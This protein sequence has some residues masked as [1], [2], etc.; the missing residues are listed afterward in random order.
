MAQWGCDAV[1]QRLG[2]L[3]S[4]L[5]GELRGD[6]VMI[7]DAA[8][9]APHILSLSFPGGMPERLVEQLAEQRVYVAPRIGRM[10]ISPHVY[11]DEEDVERFVATFRRAAYARDRVG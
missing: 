8:L 7:P 1:Q 2:M 9:R 11:N 5:A 10:R 6:G 3:S 4:R